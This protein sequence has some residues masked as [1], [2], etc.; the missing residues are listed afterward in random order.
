[1]SELSPGMLIRTNYSGPYRV[2]TVERGCTCPQYDAA[3]GGPR[4]EASPPHI[5][6]TCTL[7]EKPTEKR[8]LSHWDEETLQSLDWTYCGHK[9]ERA[10]DWIEIL[11]D[12]EGRPL[13]RQME[14]TL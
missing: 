6:L 12:P 9:A 4:S 11:E 14:L 13:P 10:P 8:W 7:P 1:M 5:H 3:K 2:E